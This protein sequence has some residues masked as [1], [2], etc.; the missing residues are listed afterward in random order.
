MEE[1]GGGPSGAPMGDSWRFGVLFC[2]AMMDVLVRWYTAYQM[3]PVDGFFEHVRPAIAPSDPDVRSVEA[4]D[5]AD[6]KHQLFARG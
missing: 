1:A 6:L 3:Q 4:S 5:A 2:L